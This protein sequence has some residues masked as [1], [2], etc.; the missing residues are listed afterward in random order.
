MNHRYL[1]NLKHHHSS[2]I[3]C[4]L[5]EVKIIPKWP[6]SLKLQP[7]RVNKKCLLQSTQFLTIFSNRNACTITILLIIERDIK[8]DRII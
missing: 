5:L 3:F 8:I 4:P 2:A 6:Q 7:Y 1:K